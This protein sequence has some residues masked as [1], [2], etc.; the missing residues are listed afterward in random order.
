ML[1]NRT[2]VVSVLILT[3]CA[4]LGLRAQTSTQPTQPAQPLQPGI[5]R[6]TMSADPLSVSRK[7][8]VRVVQAFGIRGFL[9]SAVGAGIGQLT[10]TPSEWGQGGEGFAD[11]YAS[12]FGNNLNR[13]VFAFTLES[14]LHEDP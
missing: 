7:F 8:R 1:A 9:G 14:I 3:L 5:L 6:D 2:F 4:A 12:G 13:Q 10:N 11:R